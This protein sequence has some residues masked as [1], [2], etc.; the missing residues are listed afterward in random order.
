MKE[1]MSLEDF[2]KKLAAA[3]PHL[4]EIM[5]SN[6][7]MS[8]QRIEKLTQMLE[9]HTP[10]LKELS[11]NRMEAL[12]LKI[13]GERPMAGFDVALRLE[14]ANIRL[15]EGGEGILYGLLASLEASGL[16]SAEWRESGDRMIKIYR[17]IE[18]GDGSLHSATVGD[19]ELNLLSAR[20]LS[21]S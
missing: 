3:G 18:K 17:L 19:S 16:V 10:F 11:S 4:S 21:F 13:L 9:A 1:K 20:V 2:E 8:P 7:D 15:K 5:G 14:K 12:L 6:P